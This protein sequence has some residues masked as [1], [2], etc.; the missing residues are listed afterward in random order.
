VFTCIVG[1]IIGF[2]KTGVENRHRRKTVNVNHNPSHINPGNYVGAVIFPVG[3]MEKY[4][5][6]DQS[7][8]NHL[9]SPSTIPSP[10]PI[11]TSTTQ[12]TPTTPFKHLQPT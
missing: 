1:S 8:Q 6:D 7:L 2:S 3:L 11:P 4:K 12:T 9:L 5:G 10:I